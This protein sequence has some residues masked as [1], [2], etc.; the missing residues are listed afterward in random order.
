MAAANKEIYRVLGQLGTLILKLFSLALGP[1]QIVYSWSELKE[2]GT[3]MLLTRPT[4]RETP[5]HWDH[6]H[7]SYKRA[8][9]V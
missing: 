2:M 5:S 1:E 3:Y 7:I 4:N 8:G 9:L 6:R